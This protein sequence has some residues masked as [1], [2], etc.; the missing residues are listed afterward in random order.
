MKLRH[1]VAAA[2][3]SGL[4]IIS[5]PSFAQIV[6]L[7]ATGRYVFGDIPNESINVAKERARE[8]AKR[9]IAERAGVYVETYSKTS[10]YSLVT[11]EVRVVAAK[12][13]KIKRESL[14]LL[15]TD[16]QNTVLI[17]C[18]ISAEVDTDNMNLKAILDDKMYVEQ[19]L[20]LQERVEKLR[21]ETMAL[22]AAY[23]NARDNIAKQEI[24][25]QLLQNEKNFT[26]EQFF[27]KALA[28]HFKKDYGNALEAYTKAIAMKPNFP[29]AYLNRG[30]AYASLGKYQ[31]AINN[32]N[33][34][35]AL[36]PK[37]EQ[38]AYYNRGNSYLAIGKY[39]LAIA[40]YDKAIALA[41]NHVD[42]HYNKG[43]A[44]YYEGNHQ[45]AVS[46]FT[47]ALLLNPKYAKVYNNRGNSYVALGELK[48]AIADFSQ[49]I[50]L[51]PEL[52]DA[53]CNRGSA[54]DTLGNKKQ[55]R[56][57]LSQ[58]AAI[59][60]RTIAL[61]P[62]NATGYYNRAMIY[63]NMHNDQQVIADLS[64]VIALKPDY[65]YAYYYRGSAYFNLKKYELAEA[66]FSKVI[67]LNPKHSDTYNL[68][69][70]I[71]LTKN[72]EQNATSFISKALELQPN[73]PCYLDSKGEIYEHFGNNT[74]ALKFYNAALKQ[75]ESYSN[76]ELKT[77]ILDHIMRVKAKL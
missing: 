39:Q 30:S 36:H 33:Q 16:N 15:P 22:K 23:S 28:L 64:T 47:K 2:I 54:Y 53:Y 14:N 20:E 75:L 11:D 32:F 27:D 1:L 58:A 34:A 51:N 71:Y 69:A 46:E 52:G 77:N 42:S 21:K 72:D 66:D 18:S 62:K 9:Q 45:E 17:E 43:I 10:N 68:L 3:V 35:L 65:I 26:A 73:N 74:E 63:C 19:L 38:P 12:V 61:N 59:F 6:T 5:L 8:D 37:S 67:A 41:P 40:D 25:N 24:A 76:P 7:E 55:A 56:A 49:A 29:Y 57:D 70:N 48:Q 4:A 60:S 50:A 31:L 13:L 44:L